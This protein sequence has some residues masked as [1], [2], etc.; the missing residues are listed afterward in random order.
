MDVPLRL[1]RPAI[2][3]VRAEIMSTPGAKISTHV[4]KLEKDALESSSP[5]APTVIAFKAEA[6][7]V[8]QASLSE[9]PAAMTM[10]TPAATALSTALFKDL[11]LDSTPRLRF[12]TAPFGRGRP[13]SQSMPAIIEDKEPLPEPSKTL[14]EIKLTFLAI[15][16][17]VPPTVPGKVKEGKI[18][19]CNQRER[20]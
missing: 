5:V 8:P 3:F 1:L 17:S 11:T 7:D 18:L 13:T 19:K 6:G 12:A 15:P 16:Y 9:F 14:T 4:P 2:V 20:S 10:T